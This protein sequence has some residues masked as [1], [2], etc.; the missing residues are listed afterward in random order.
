MK[1]IK[2]GNMIF[3]NGNK[4]D[5]RSTKLQSMFNCSN[6]T[7]HYAMYTLHRKPTMW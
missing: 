3:D 5:P 4:T 2:R 7:I 6:D 1:Y